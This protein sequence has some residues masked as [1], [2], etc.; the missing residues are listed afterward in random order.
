MVEVLL[1]HPQK[2][3]RPDIQA[4]YDLSSFGDVESI[5][6][7]YNDPPIRTSL[8]IPSGVVKPPTFVIP[9]VRRKKIEPGRLPCGA[10]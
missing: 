4:G 10:P 9:T 2:D 5:H 8:R 3:A 6:G 7:P 1:F